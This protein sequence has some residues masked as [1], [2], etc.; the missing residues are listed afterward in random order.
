MTPR[1]IGLLA[2]GLVAVLAAGCISN[3]SN[4]NSI[5]NLNS[6]PPEAIR[7]INASKDGHDGISVYFV[8]ADKDGNPTTSDGTVV[9]NIGIGSPL[10]YTK[11]YDI[12]KSDF[13]ETTVG[14][15]IY[16]NK[17]IICGLGYIPYTQFSQEPY[18]SGLENVPYRDSS[19]VT[20]YFKTPDGKTL[21]GL[22]QIQ[23]E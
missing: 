15:G 17:E 20:I 14:Q 1:I 12:H 13:K 4:L 5:S 8:L 9:L 11:T 22:Y 16:A 18:T 3:N 19:T 7:E 23:W 21:R 2:I 10:L 6:N